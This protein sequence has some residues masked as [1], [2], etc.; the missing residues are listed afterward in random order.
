M[1]AKLNTERLYEQLVGR[2]VKWAE[3]CSDIR[4]AVIVG[5]RARVDHPADEWADLDIIV[6]TTNP[7][8]YVS[9]SDW[10]EKVG[11][12][13]MTFVEPT[14]G[15]DD[16]ERRVLFE[17]MLDVDFAIIPMR[18]A[19]QLL[20]GGVPPEIAAQTSNVFG[21][22]MRVILDKDGIAAKL[23]M[24][25]SSI[26]TPAPSP[27]TQHE[28][29]EV[30]NDFLYHAVFTAKHLRRGELW[31]TVTCLNCYMQRL[32]LRMM[33]WHAHATHGWNYDTWFRGRFLEEW[34][35]PQA[36]KGLRGAFAHYDEDDIKRALLAAMDLFRWIAVETADELSYP[37]P[38][39]ADEQITKWIRTCL[40]YPRGKTA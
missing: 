17:G 26:E 15:G 32:L 28:F 11:N 2:F 7:E 33:E 16:M 29:L 22:G 19:Q 6:I 8:H 27:P 10:I 25:V 1:T 40:S 31:W 35:H 38:G 9:A 18:K 14:S 39:E 21:R 13:L 30:V 12:P 36:L 20:Q 34:V 5:S 3:T 4:A 37:Y 23:R 24:I